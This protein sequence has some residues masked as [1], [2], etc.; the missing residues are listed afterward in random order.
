MSLR[1]EQSI[2]SADVMRLMLWAQENGYEW[3]FG[4]AQRTAEQQAIYYKTGRSKTMNSFHLKRLAID[5]F[6]FRDGKLLATKEEVQPIG[7][8]WEVMSAKNQWGGNWKSFKDV[9]HFERRA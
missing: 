5:L 8:A 1:Q 7:N 4:E 6:F 3:T 9:P 2:F